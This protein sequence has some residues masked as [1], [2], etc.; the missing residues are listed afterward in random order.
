MKRA[1][2]AAA[3]LAVILAGCTP[4]LAATAAPAA[5][6]LKLRATG[7]ELSTE[8]YGI[9]LKRLEGLK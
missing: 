4:A 8:S 9:A 5:H 6:G 3:V 7:I 2:A 1:H